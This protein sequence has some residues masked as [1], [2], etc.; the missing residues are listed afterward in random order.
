MTT[1]TE[2]ND[3]L[4]NDPNADPE[5]IDA[6]GGDDRITV[7]RPASQAPPGYADSAIVTVN[8]GS[9]FDTL[10]GGGNFGRWEYDPATG[11]GSYGI[12]SSSSFNYSVTFTSIERF[13]LSGTWFGNSGRIDTG[14]GDDILHFSPFGGSGTNLSLWTHGGNDQVRIS[15]SFAN[16]VAVTLAGDDIID[17]SMV[18]GGSVGGYGGTGNDLYILGSAGINVSVHE[19]A[20]EGIDEIRTSRSVF[21]LVANVENLTGTSTSAQTLNGN[22]L[23]NAIVAGQGNNTDFLYGFAG[24]DSLTGNNGQDR[25]DGGEGSD[26]ADYSR[27]LG[28]L[29]VVVNLSADFAAPFGHPTFGRGVSPNEAIDTYGNPDLLVSIENARGTA[30]AD[31]LYGSAG[32][33]RFWGMGGN[34]HLEGGAG[35][36]I[37]DGGTGADRM[38]GGQGDDTYYVDDAGDTTEENAGEGNDTVF[39]SAASYRL[40]ANIENLNGTSAN[41]QALTGNDQNNTIVGTNGNDTIDGGGGADVMIGLQG[42]DV[43]IVDNV[44]DQVIE[45]ANEGTDEIRTGLSTYSIEA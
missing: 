32:A 4:T 29:G 38:I 16:A 39:S 43:Y 9:G 8:G 27:E 15:G 37:L 36:D 44:N 22:E 3:T 26:T 30:Q 2:G 34:D 41:G 23:N 10:V 33:N 28:M 21:G 42:D 40:G 11:N 31:Y 19:F 12:R 6:L 7:N 14:E 18:T 25:L 5:T 13:E 45:N 17:F 1:G 35:N 24:D 20:N